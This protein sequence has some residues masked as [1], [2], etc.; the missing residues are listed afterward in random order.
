MIN[1]INK[2]IKTK[3][4]HLRPFSEEDLDAYATMMGDEQVARWFPKGD[5]YTPEESEKSLNNILSHWMKHGYGLWAITKKKDCSFIGRCGLN[6]ILDTSEV[7]IDFIIKTNCWNNGYAT[8]A[9]RAALFY[10]FKILKLD[11][12][13]A[14]SKLENIASRKVIEKIGMHHIRNAI[15]WNIICAKYEIVN[16]E[17]CVSF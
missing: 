6:L 3:R 2:E 10:G 5:S 14:L 1:V 8:E 17:Y 4:L 9:A 12:I 16:K 15:Y 13:I 7:E 11:K